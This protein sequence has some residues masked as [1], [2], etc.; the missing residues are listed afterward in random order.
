ML[1]KYLVSRTGSNIY[2]PHGDTKILDMY[3]PKYIGDMEGISYKSEYYGIYPVFLVTT[4]LSDFD[5]NLL[6]SY[7]DVFLFPDNEKELIDFDKL[8]NWL[9]LNKVP[10]DYLDSTWTHEEAIDSIK[11]IFTISQILGGLH[12]QQKQEFL[13]P[14]T[15]FEDFAPIVQHLLTMSPS[16]G[17]SV[18]DMISNMTE[19]FIKPIK[20]Q[21]K[22]NK[23]VDYGFTSY[24]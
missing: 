18:F 2:I 23:G 8:K 20:N 5:H 24:I 17:K 11:K 21:S 13:T 4:D 19:K 12:S 1:R 6:S 22:N 3:R 9:S 7:A 14:D 10:S 15:K 16:N